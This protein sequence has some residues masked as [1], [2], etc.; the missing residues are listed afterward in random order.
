M[1]ISLSGIVAFCAVAY[2]QGAII[3]PG[4]ATYITPLIAIAACVSITRSTELKKAVLLLTA[5]IVPYMLFVALYV[6]PIS[7]PSKLV[8]FYLVFAV[9]GVLLAMSLSDTRIVRWTP[10]I[11]LFLLFPLIVLF[12]LISESWDDSRRTILGHNPIWLSRAVGLG[13]LGAIFVASKALKPAKFALYALIFLGLL[14]IIQTGSRGPLYAFALASLVPLLKGL[15]IGSAS[16]AALLAIGFSGY[17]A[18][19]WASIYYPDLRILTLS[20]SGGTGAIRFEIWNEAFRLISTNPSGLGVGRYYVH[21][22]G[23]K[24]VHNIF[25]EFMVEWG[26]TVGSFFVFFILVG[27]LGLLLL[28]AD[29]VFLKSLAVYEIVN[30]SVSGDVT[31]PRFLYA[32][33]LIGVAAMMLRLRTRNRAAKDYNWSLR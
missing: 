33:S 22:L 27:C 1:K 21:E 17:G 9:F 16:I 2:V 14:V 19:S 12:L 24:Y 18:L 7:D 30:A 3:F 28:P 20:A 13:M 11:F 10:H 8:Q 25:L 4:L 32:L 31:S 6:S 5:A 29:F 26:V 15:R 23:V